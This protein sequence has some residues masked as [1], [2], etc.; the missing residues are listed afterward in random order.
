M[1]KLSVKWIYIKVY[2][3][4][5]YKLTHSAWILETSHAFLSSAEFH[6]HLDRED[7]TYYGSE[8]DRFVEVCLVVEGGD[9]LDHIVYI[10]VETRENDS[11]GKFTVHFYIAKMIHI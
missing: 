5:L 7:K 8:D 3:L 9:P 1:K 2:S 6:I 11:A 4:A 10:V